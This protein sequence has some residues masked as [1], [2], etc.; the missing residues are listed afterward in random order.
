MKHPLHRKHRFV[1]DPKVVYT[2]HRVDSGQVGQGVLLVTEPRSELNAG[3]IVAFGSAHPPLFDWKEWKLRC[4]GLPE[5]KE[6][7]VV[8]HQAQELA[9]LLWARIGEF[10]QRTLDVGGLTPEQKQ[11]WIQSGLALSPL[12]GACTQ[13]SL[14]FGLAWALIGEWTSRL[15]FPVPAGAGLVMGIPVPCLRN[16]GDAR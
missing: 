3:F 12:M 13:Y 11:H 16:T 4:R 2:Q 1:H 7:E 5:K 8:L 9:S 14:D 6:E 10:L 15:L